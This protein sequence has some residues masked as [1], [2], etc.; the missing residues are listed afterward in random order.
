[1][2]ELNEVEQKEIKLQIDALKLA[3]YDDLDYLG[4]LQEAASQAQGR[5]Q[6]RRLKIED[7]LKQLRG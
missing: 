7:L 3:S 2:S 5:V 4:K 1:M 6:E